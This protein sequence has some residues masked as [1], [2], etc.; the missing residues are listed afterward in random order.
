MTDADRERRRRTLYAAL[1]FCQLEEHPA[2]PEVTA[3]KRW[4]S[5]W[6][7]I[8]HIVVGMERQGYAVSL[9]QIP[10]DGWTASFADH[11]LLPPA[12]PTRRLRS[13]RSSRRRGGR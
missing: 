5:T 12:S 6:T 7:G 4:L 9:S 1:G 2:M 3:L 8:G 13:A 10:S 11:R